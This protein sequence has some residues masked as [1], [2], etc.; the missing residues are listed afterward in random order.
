MIDG[1]QA[2]QI[3]AFEGIFCVPHGAAHRAARTRRNVHLS[4]AGKQKHVF[5]S[6]CTNKHRSFLNSC[7]VLFGP[8]GDEGP[9]VRMLSGSFDA[10][11]HVLCGFFLHLGLLF[12]SMCDICKL[13]VWTSPYVCTLRAYC[14]MHASR[15]VQC[16]RKPKLCSK[17]TSCLDLRSS[18]S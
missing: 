7:A 4:A 17:Q 6:H 5:L 14:V 2:D 1:Q 18:S 8:T 12:L 10:R 3:N 16:E 13:C 15:N 9:L 11:R